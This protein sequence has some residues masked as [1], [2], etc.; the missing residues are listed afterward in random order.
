MPDKTLNQKFARRSF[1]DFLLGAS[2]VAWLG[3]ILYPVIRYLKP[4]P[5]AGPSGPTHLTREELAKLEKE[6]F[7]IVPVSGKRVLVLQNAAQQI[8]ALDAKCTHEGCTVQYLPGESA[9]WCACHNARFD[10]DGRVVSGPPPRPLPKYVAER[11]EDG[12]ILIVAERRPS[13]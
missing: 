8:L 2:S 1:L 4:L 3:S 5:R 6:H 13:E 10:L 12:G 11:Q 7:V 9:I